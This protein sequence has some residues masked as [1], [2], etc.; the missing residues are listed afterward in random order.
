[1]TATASSLAKSELE[2]LL[3]ENSNPLTGVFDESGGYFTDP[4]KTHTHGSFSLYVDYSLGTATSIEI[5]IQEA[6]S[7]K[8]FK[9]VTI[10]KPSDDDGVSLVRTHVLSIDSDSSRQGSS[11]S[12]EIKVEAREGFWVRMLAKATG[13]LATAPSL[14]L[15][16]HG[17]A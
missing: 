3:S 5:L 9:D 4:F 14:V 1:M 11:G 17:G 16:A 8:N 10:V 13:T 2:C 15:S 7:E 6:S 12:L